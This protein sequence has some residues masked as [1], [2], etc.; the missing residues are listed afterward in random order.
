MGARGARHA[1]ERLRTVSSHG[2]ARYRYGGRF[3]NAAARC[4]EPAMV[5]RSTLENRHRSETAAGIVR[6]AGAMRQGLGGGRG[7][8]GA[9][10]GDASGRG[11]GR[12]GCRR[13]GYG[14][15]ARWR[16]E[17]NDRD[18]RRGVCFDRSSGD[19]P[20]GTTAYVL[21][22]DSGTVAR[23]GRD[24]GGG[25]VAALVSRQLRS[26]VAGSA[27]ARSARK[28]MGAIPTTCLPRKLLRRRR[29]RK[30]RCGR[31]I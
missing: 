13:R 2:R 27:E 23:D 17:R 22:C 16:G 15:R 28:R 25:I 9:A 10:G 7:S 18:I 24:P 1:A 19:G 6:I 3:R 21:S 31:R 30:G 26:G 4:G 14:H 11:R 29:G 20:S 5:E 8:H 12:P